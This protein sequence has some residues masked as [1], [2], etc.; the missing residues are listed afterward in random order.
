MVDHEQVQR[1]K[2]EKHSFMDV[3]GG[4]INKESLTGN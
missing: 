2:G 1:N 3:G 4:A